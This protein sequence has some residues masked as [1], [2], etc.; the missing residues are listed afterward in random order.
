[1]GQFVAGCGESFDCC[2]CFSDSVQLGPVASSNLSAH[3]MD[4]VIDPQATVGWKPAQV[5]T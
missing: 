3:R 4:V 2:G 1:M 5:G